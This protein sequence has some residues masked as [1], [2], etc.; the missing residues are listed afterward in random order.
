[1]RRT[2]ILIASVLMLWSAAGAASAHAELESMSPAVGS[3]V[4]EAPT[5]VV[6]TFGEDVQALGTS[7]V[8]LDPKGASVQDGDVAIEGVRATQPLKALAEPGIYHVNFRV[9][10]ADGHVVTGSETFDFEPPTLYSESP[11][12]EAT[13]VPETSPITHASS[14]VGFWITGLLMVLLAMGAF[15]VIRH[16][17]N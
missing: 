3:V 12:G 1:M 14:T 6:L 5:Q 2:A 9:V 15:G 11:V 10:S 16:R 8:V 17:R 7:V 4:T 13:S